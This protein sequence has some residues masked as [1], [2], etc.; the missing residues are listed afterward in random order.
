MTRIGHGGPG[1]TTAAF[2][3]GINALTTSLNDNTAAEINFQQQRDSKTFTDKHGHAL[4]Q[5][6]RNYCDVLTDDLLPDIH[7]LLASAPKGGAHGILDAHFR[8][9]AEATDLPITS[10]NAPVSTARLM[11]DVFR[12][13]APGDAG[14]NF[15][16]GLSPFAVVCDGHS[17]VVL[18]QK[19]TKQAGI[20]ESGTSVSLSDAKSLTSSDVRFP[21][22]PYVAAEKLYG[23]SVVVDVFHGANHLVSGSIRDAVRE[24][25]P[26]L[27]QLAN[28]HHDNPA[29]G[30]DLICRVMCEMQ[31]D[32]FAW[33]ASIASG[34][35]GVGVPDFRVIISRVM[36]HRADSLAP[37]PL[38]WHNL[39]TAPMRERE[40]KAP[41][42]KELLGTVPTFNAKGD[43]KL[44]S[45]FKDSGHANISAMTAGHDVEIP[46]H[47]GSPVCLVWA[48]KGSCSASC[49]RKEQHVQCGQA[50]NRKLHELMDA[51]GVANPQP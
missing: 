49:K 46:K 18:A 26:S 34:R 50:T 45:R 4:S 12:T 32:C 40:A 19:L 30:M 23:W 37:L 39:P 27:F 10:R 6:V 47:N 20:V 16:R 1:L 51:C 7:G 42:R 5:L 2:Q 9:R 48:L 14:L 41:A 43:K 36:T 8:Q 21:T 17:E 31:Q 44:L 28:Q 29:V 22:L 24:I 15:G 13:C 33:L 35:H 11:E 25:A 3:A 38:P